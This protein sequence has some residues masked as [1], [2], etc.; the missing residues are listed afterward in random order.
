MFNFIKIELFPVSVGPAVSGV[1]LTGEGAS[2]EPD[3]K[4]QA[5]PMDLPVPWRELQ[6]NPD[7]FSL[8]QWR[9]AIS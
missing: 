5:A 2:G 9:T 6:A 8:L 7:V 1:V 4:G 3:R